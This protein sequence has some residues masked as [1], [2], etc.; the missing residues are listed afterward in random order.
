MSRLEQAEETI[1]R[2]L[3]EIFEEELECDPGVL[4]T[5]TSVTATSDKKM[6]RVGLTV[7]PETEGVPV[8]RTILRRVPY[9]RSLLGEKICSKSILELFFVLETFKEI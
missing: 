9:F 4:V 5:L 7:F 2:A 8:L 1:H 3:S 6:Y